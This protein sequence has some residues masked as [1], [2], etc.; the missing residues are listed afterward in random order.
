MP[1]AQLYGETVRAVL[2]AAERVAPT[3]L[4]A[5][6]GKVMTVD[7][8]LATLLVEAAVHHL[9]LLVALDRPGPAAGPLAWS[10]GSRRPCS[11]GRS[12]AASTTG[13][14]PG[15]HRPAVPPLDLAHRIPL[16]G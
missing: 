8:L 6:Q 9:D 5:T 3:D 16:F 11:G 14:R 7:D 1:L 4:V 10:G 2:I 13:S 12:R 15:G